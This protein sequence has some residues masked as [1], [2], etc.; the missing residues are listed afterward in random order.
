MET[1]LYGL[2][3]S[4]IFAS[5][6]FLPSFLTACALRWGA[7]LPLLNQIAQPSNAE[8]SWFTHEYTILALG[9]L[10][11]VEILA[12]K[13]PHARELMSYVDKYTKPALAALTMM[14]V[15]SISDAS[16]LKTIST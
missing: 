4:G 3:L 9:I 16:F 5:R 12:D 10:S 1:L 7:D 2:G 15:L 11:L 14:G 6:A 8:P 13:D